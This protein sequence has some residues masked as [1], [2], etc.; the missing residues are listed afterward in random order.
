MAQC[1]LGAAVR[2]T[3]YLAAKT[4]TTGPERET[5]AASTVLTA[6]ERE[7]LE[8]AQRGDDDAFGRLAGAYRGELYAHCYR[9]LGSAAD[10]EDALQETLLRGWRALPRFEGRSSVR[11][12][13]YKIATNACLRAIERRPRRV[14]PVDYGPAADP[15]DGPAEPVTETVWLEP[16]PDER[17]GLATSLASPEA[18]YEQREGVELAFI[19]AL[20][21]LPARQRAVL[22]LRDVLGFS[23]R[24]VAGV[25][26]T[27]PASVHSALQ[28]ARQTI[29]T[30]LPGPSQQ[31]AMRS[32]GDNRLRE[33]AQR[34]TDALEAG[35]VEVIVAMLAEDATFA[36]P[37]HPDWCR[38]RDALSESWLM[39]A[40]YPTGLRYLPSRANGQ[41]APGAY[42]LD[43]KR[44]CYLPV[45]L[46]VL[47]WQGARITAITAFR[48]PEVFPRFGLR[49]KLPR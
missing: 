43:P 38:G 7:L 14:L 46:D 49:E 30:R 39:P 5:G 42:K 20:Q 36:M 37:P 25:L 19:A 45:A 16:Y 29:R 44:G 26:D 12:W 48:T 28:R 40:G 22:I 34:L 11:S 6:S 1:H 33:L 18:R 41:F 4:M 2:R 32:L 17:L 35:Q 31:E 15:H 3:C 47:S 21:H 27:T 23:A 8:A 13:L 24:E 9:M 10:A